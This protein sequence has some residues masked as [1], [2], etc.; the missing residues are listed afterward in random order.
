MASNALP[1]YQSTLLSKDIAANGIW[2]IAVLGRAD[3]RGKTPVKQF[4]T[5]V[6]Q[7]ICAMAS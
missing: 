5:I 2:N 4:F 7:V 1:R 3:K 6:D